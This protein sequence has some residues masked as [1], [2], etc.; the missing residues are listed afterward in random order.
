M[1]DRVILAN[2]IRAFNFLK[3]VDS[4]TMKGEQQEFCL[5]CNDYIRKDKLKWHKYR[6]PHTEFVNFKSKRHNALIDLA[7][8]TAD[9][10]TSLRL[11][12][13]PT[14]QNSFSM[15]DLF[16]LCSSFNIYPFNIS[17]GSNRL[18]CVFKQLNISASKEKSFVKVLET[19]KI[20]GL[21]HSDS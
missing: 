1:F 16:N 14:S 18:V 6:H 20:F 3:T 8:C 17:K 15:Q 5:S 21:L 11:L 10:H 7:P 4:L 13:L 12:K 9:T 2:K 19:S